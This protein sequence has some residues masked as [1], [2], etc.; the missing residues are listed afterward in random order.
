MQLSDPADLPDL[1]DRS[2][3]SGLPAGARSLPEL[4][5]RVAAVRGDAAA[6]AG[7]G[8]QLGYAELDRRAGAVAARLTAAGLGRGDLV[9][10][11]LERS[12][13]APAW[14]LG[15]LR[16][17]AA[18]VPLDPSYPADRLRFMAGDAGLAALVGDPD[19]AAA[20]G[21]DALPVID[22]EAAAAEPARPAEAG[23][24]VAAEPGPD[25]PA[26]VIYTSGSTGVP[27][28]CV[29]THGNVLELLRATLPL[30]EL[31]PDDRWTLFHS[32]S[33]DFS[34]W[35]LWG[36][37][38]T[39]ATAVPVPAATAQAPED[40]LRLL[41]DERITVLNQVPSAFRHLAREYADSGAPA[42][43]LRYVV[44]GGESVDLDVV[45]GFLAASAAAPGPVPVMVNMYGI[46][47]ITVHATHL[48][49]TPEQ[50][51]G[52][53]PSPIGRPLP[54][55]AIELR[56]DALRLVPDGGTGEMWVAG[57]GVA[58]GYLNRPELTAER[59]RTLDGR[60]MYRTG[61]L[62]RRLPDGGLAY[63]GRNDQQVKLRGHR[64]ELG[65][66]EAGLRAAPQVRDAAALVV[67]DDAG[68]ELL[69]ALVVPAGPGEADVAALRRFARATMPAQLVP[70][71]FHPVE[72]LPLTS[73]G[74]LDRKALAGLV[75]KA[76]APKAGASREGAPQE[77]ASQEGAPRARVLVLD[78]ID[79]GAL[80]E[81]RRQH[82]V[83]VALRPPVDEL[84]RL[85]R[86]QE[87]IVLRSGVRLDAPVI[88]AAG[89]LRVIARAGSGIDNIDVAAARAAGVTVFNIPAVSAPAVAELALGLMLTVG[90]H[91]ALA[92]RQVRS[93]IWNKAALSGVELGGK[94]LGLVGYGRIGSRIAALG[95]ALGMRVLVDVARPDADRRHEL[96]RLDYELA[97][98][99][100]LL[101][102]ADVVCLAVPLTDRTHHLIDAAALAAMKPTSL[103]VNV[104]RGLVVDEDAL[105]EALAEGRIGG[106]GLDVVAEEGRP[107]RLHE[108]D[109]VVITPHIGAMSVDS[110]V[111]IGRI[112]VDSVAAALAGREVPNQ[113]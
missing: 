72:E 40:F 103:L 71:R 25:D 50:L 38:A 10:V 99:K 32:A 77:G 76:A 44:F 65:E 16:S 7:G 79:P 5:A 70:N 17:G 22:P 24:P 48:V 26:Y 84:L 113:C 62:A 68:N 33:F 30:F 15:V 29:V 61:D 36:A 51:A 80:D 59:F 95:R 78:P 41:A 90:R 88:A 4:F 73:S 12:H 82:D 14:I 23:G 8:E 27:K 20:C 75:P 49:L 45:R 11:L 56:D 57:S 39:G 101:P 1:P 87:V 86:D 89:R 67:R 66:V 6:V 92:D 81:L 69:T 108:L 96:E 94:T 54:H 35:E 19:R 28:G 85:V 63:L 9:G 111:R 37:W 3:L 55:L 83:T 58:D 60:R 42:T 53:T 93:G 64:V 21:L 2:D 107:N 112:L 47:E 105:Y 100:T 31:G 34:V 98:L 43:A 104:S 102:A 52:D 110:Q 109:N 97:P 74:K 106:A 91:L 18:Y 13:R 46:T